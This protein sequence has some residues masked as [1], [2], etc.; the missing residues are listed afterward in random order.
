[1]QLGERALKRLAR[2]QHRLRNSLQPGVAAHQR[3]NAPRQLAAALAP[4]LADE[5]GPD[6]APD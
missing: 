2:C 5:V 1:M 4:A 3:K 6:P